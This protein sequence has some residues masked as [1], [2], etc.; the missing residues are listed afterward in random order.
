M[1][2][3]RAAL[4]AVIASASASEVEPPPPSDEPS[5]ATAEHH[6][7]LR[8]DR[9]FGKPHWEIALDG[10]LDPERSRRIDDIRLW[11][12]NT[13]QSDRRKP[14]SRYLSRY[15]RFGY[16]RQDDGSLLVHLAGDG[17][18][19]AFTVALTADGSPV[20]F[21]DVR[22]ADAQM[23]PNCQCASATLVARRVLGIPVGISALRVRCRDAEGQAHDAIV[24]YRIIEDDRPYAPGG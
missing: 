1:L 2:A 8:I 11:W 19:Y 18:E 20:V 24:P 23:V 5:A 21:A 17:K 14:F 22:I 16:A 13:R 3:L 7:V 6:E 10:W 15:R 12:V 9:D 4:L